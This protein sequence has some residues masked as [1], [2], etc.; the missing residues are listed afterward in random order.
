MT[1]DSPHHFFSAGLSSAAKYSFTAGWY[2][3]GSLRFLPAAPDEHREEQHRDAD[4]ER[5]TTPHRE[6]E[7]GHSPVVEKSRRAQM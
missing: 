1:F 3:G 4:G 7:H 5:P 6:T 2:A